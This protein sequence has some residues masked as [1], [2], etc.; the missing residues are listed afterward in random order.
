V[1]ALVERL[2]ALRPA[3]GFVDVLYPGER[4][5][6]MAAERRAG[7]VPVEE[8]ELEAIA[9]AAVDCGMADLAERARGLGT[10]VA[11]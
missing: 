8:A 10:P 3:K 4:G 7:G 5:D 11:G 2:H 1:D 9:T 6:R